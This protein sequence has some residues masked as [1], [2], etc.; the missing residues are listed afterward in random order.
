[1]FD[2]QLDA[3]GVTRQVV[4]S[5]SHF[6]AAPWV[7]ALTNAVVLIPRRLLPVVSG[8]KLRVLDVPLEM[9]SFQVSMLWHERSHREPAHRWLRQAVIDALYPAPKRG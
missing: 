2:Q 7:A 9:P 4:L 6:L 8:W 1:M 5:T 3:L